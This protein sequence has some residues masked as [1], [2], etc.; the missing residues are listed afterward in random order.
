ML[1][2]K[3][4]KLTLIVIFI[5]AFV[6]IMNFF[7]QKQV[8]VKMPHEN[9][10][11]FQ[12]LPK[13]NLYRLIGPLPQNIEKT[14]Y[15]GPKTLLKKNCTKCNQDNQDNQNQI[16]EDPIGISSSLT[17][18]YDDI[19]MVNIYKNQEIVSNNII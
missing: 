19:G 14:F 13:N 4:Y 3:I 9:S 11:S 17:S 1:S 6:Q 18:E 10:N 7:N 2:D 16:F 8:I 5:L 12:D 15:L